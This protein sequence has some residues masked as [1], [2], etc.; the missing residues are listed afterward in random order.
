[1]LAGSFSLALRRG[2][3]SSGLSAG[4]YSVRTTVLSTGAGGSKG[5]GAGDEAGLGRALGVV[6]NGGG[7]GVAGGDELHVTGLY[8]KRE[9]G[10]GLGLCKM[11]GYGR[12]Q[13]GQGSETFIEQC[14]AK[15]CLQPLHCL[16]WP[17]PWQASASRHWCTLIL[18]GFA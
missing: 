8:G 5:E 13:V 3:V 14:C 4:R 9:A 18:E 1:M 15:L 16:A 17:R 11:G 10:S 12:R 6:R 7:G 2:A